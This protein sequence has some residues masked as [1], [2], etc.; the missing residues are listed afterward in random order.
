MIY[1]WDYWGPVSAV[2]LIAWVPISLWLFSRYRP[3]LAAAM[4]LVGGMMWLPEAAG[5][6]F[7]LLPPLNKFSISALCALLGA[8][9]VPGRRGAGCSGERLLDRLRP[10][11]DD[12]ADPA[13][14]VARIKHRRFGPGEFQTAD[15]RQG[16]SGPLQCL[17][18][19]GLQSGQFARIS[20]IE[21]PR[22]AALG[23]KQVAWQW[24]A[25]MRLLRQCREPRDRVGDDLVDRGMLV[26]DA[27]D[28]RGV[29]AVFEQPP[30]QIGEQILMA[31][32]WR[33]DAA[34]AVHLVGRHLVIERLAH[35]VQ[36]LEFPVTALTGQF[37][38]RGEVCALWVANCG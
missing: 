34:R 5:F 29:G 9:V 2:A 14:P 22:V 17:G 13:P 1:K 8:C 15:D 18:D 36:A 25:R 4:V 31:A 19:A 26:D 7:P 27:V 37:E 33:V 20:E 6:D 38:D 32:D 11:C 30:H 10:G 24:D 21:P 16:T 35:A 12:R 28:E 23:V 3:A